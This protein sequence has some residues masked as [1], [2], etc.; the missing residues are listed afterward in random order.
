MLSVL[1][2]PERVVRAGSP[3]LVSLDLQMPLGLGGTHLE[4]DLLE[5]ESTIELRVQC[6]RDFLGISL[7]VRR[8]PQMPY[9]SRP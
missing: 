8:G 3:V 1:I 7:D 6:L 5:L 4:V 2:A 9:S